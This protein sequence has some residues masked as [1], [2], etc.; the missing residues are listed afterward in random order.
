[1]EFDS[2][3]DG[4]R[5]VTYLHVE[6]AH[7]VARPRSPGKGIIMNARH[8]LFLILFAAPFA[9]GQNLRVTTTT[10]PVDV[11]T[12]GD[13]DFINATTPKW[14]FTIDVSLINPVPG[15]LEVEMEIVGAVTLASGEQF[16]RAL[17]LQTTPFLV[18]PSRSF[19]NLDFR[20]AGLRATYVVDQNAKKRFE[21][22]ALATG[23]MPPGSYTFVITVRP[24]GSSTEVPVTDEAR[25]ILSNPSRVDLLLPLDR[26]DAVNQ[27]PLFQWIFDGTR[28]RL[29]V[30]EKL[31]GQVTL[32]ETASGVPVLETEV[33][34]TGFQYPSSGVRVLE[35]GKTYVWHVE[36]LLR[37]SGGN[38]QVIPS[39]LR[40]FT[41]AQGP[42]SASQPSILDALERALGPQYKSMFDQLRAEGFTSAGAMRLDGAALSTVEVLRLLNLF[43][44]NPDAL[45]SV[46]TE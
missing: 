6:C 29:K 30:F 4:M 9:L 12:I 24:S 7:S 20:N 41:I 37:T 21:E 40:S 36:G 28:S 34:T 19:T 15:G 18:N 45:L 43:Q 42:G 38:E 10:A 46:K 39:V 1:M 14:L 16:D 2:F 8:V 22:T 5:F 32:E 26:D 13:V 23:T 31:P 3:R 25:F 44:S 33:A 27:F 17:F 11:L 35:A